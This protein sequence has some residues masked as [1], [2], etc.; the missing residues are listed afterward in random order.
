MRLGLVPVVEQVRANP[1]RESKDP[2]VCLW[3]GWY[4]SWVWLFIMLSHHEYLYH[5]LAYLA[6]LKIHYKWCFYASRN[7]FKGSACV[8][9]LM[10]LSLGLYAQVNVTEQLGKKTC[11]WASRPGNSQPC[12]ELLDVRG[13]A[14]MHIYERSKIKCT[15]Q[16]ARMCSLIC[17]FSVRW[18][19]ILFFS[20]RGS[21]DV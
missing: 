16:T 4:A 21:T 20:Q 18:N 11:L 1:F 9:K 6:L 5:V 14:I 8:K 12:L 2:N 19:K 17:V 7:H 10:L 15:G 13:W 3:R